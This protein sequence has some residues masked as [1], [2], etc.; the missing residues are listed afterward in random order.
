MPN[1]LLRVL[2]LFSGIGGF[3][4]GLER[5]R[6]F[7]TIAFCEQ[8]PFCR[9]VLDKHWPGVAC[10][11]DVRSL[12][13]ATLSA[14]GLPRPDVICGGFPCQDIS[15][16]GKAAGLSGARSGLWFEF[17]RIVQEM[18]P[19]WVIIENVTILRSRGLD[20]ILRG[21]D[22]IGY[23]AEWHCISAGSIGASHVRDR[24]WIAA[25]PRIEGME[26][27]VEGPRLGLSRPAGW[28]GEAPRPTWPGIGSSR[29]GDNRWVASGLRR[30]DD[31]LSDVVDR[32]RVLGNSL[33]P[34]IPE[35]IGN[36]ILSAEMQEEI[37]RAAA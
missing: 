16:A 11:D 3:S 21:L 28:R 37:S 7:Q 36:A 13:A 35:M 18:S 1:T 26:R 27:Q 34:A 25:Y 4:L 6:G 33:V 8:N 20:Q 19:D 10:Y 2:D 5:T 14:D 17:L 9:Q 29:P 24:I 23:D 22:E 30:T 32:L 12:T 31:G 15:L